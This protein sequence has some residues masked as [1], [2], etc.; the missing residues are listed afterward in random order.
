MTSPSP[1][2]SI[3][4]PDLAALLGQWRDQ[5][6]ASLNCHQLGKIVSFE[7]AKQ[8]AVVS[9]AVVRQVGNETTEYPLL[10]DV[11]LFVLRGGTAVLWMPIAVG[12]PCLVLFNDRDIDNWFATGAAAVPNSPRVHSLADGLALVGFSSLAS[13]IAPPDAGTMRLSYGTSFFAIT[14]AGQVLAESSQGGNISLTDKVRIAN[15][16]L[17]LKAGIDTLCS[18]LTAWVNTGGSTPNAAT[19]AAINAVQTAFASLLL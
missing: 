17:T 15:A 14:N 2:G 3:Q 8:T 7:A 4:N 13:L 9:L 11:P 1:F 19:I 10:V 12:D 5:I 18:A 16:S 6:F